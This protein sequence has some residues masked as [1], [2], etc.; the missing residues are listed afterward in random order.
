MSVPSLPRQC[1]PCPP[2]APFPLTCLS[3]G[4]IVEEVEGVQERPE[5][6]ALPPE[7]LQARPEAPRRAQEAVLLP[8][9][10]ERPEARRA[11]VLHPCPHCRRQPN[12]PPSLSLRLEYLEKRSEREGG[13]LCFAQPL[14]FHDNIITSSSAALKRGDA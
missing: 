3:L 10:Q 1:T 5:R 9:Q 12:R 11:Q 7:E 13:L 6:A 4:H 8:A 14:I 2:R